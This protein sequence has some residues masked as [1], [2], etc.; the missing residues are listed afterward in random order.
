MLFNM[1]D[2]LAVARKHKFA[3]PA[4]NTGTIL[5]LKS[6]IECC[7]ARNA[8]LIL[9]I[10]PKELNNQ[11]EWIAAACRKA[12][13]SVKI[14]VVIHLDHGATY[15]EV[16][17]AIRCGFTSVMIDYSDKPLEENIAMTK[18][19]VEIAHPLGVSV[20]AELGHMVCLEE[21][22]YRETEKTTYVTSYTDPEEAADFV[23]KTGVDTLAVC[24]GQAHGFYPEGFVAKFNLELLAKISKATEIPLVMHGGSG[25]PQDI[26][27][28]AIQNGV[29]KVN[30]SA[31]VKSAF[32]R[33][34]LEVLS[35]DPD[36]REPFEIY[37]EPYKDMQAVMYSKIESLHT[38]DKMRLYYEKEPS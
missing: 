15:E 32:Y 23:R 14:P 24:F 30:L 18:K 17:Q 27:D 9:E 38:A 36:L 37:V 2:L 1:K 26:M 5:I 12:A 35:N 21:G 8:P 25:T 6:A 34:T 3:V 28:G 16:M 33:K 13:N 4:F 19:I 20:E 10:H 31:D 11:G 29:C 7:V 22:D